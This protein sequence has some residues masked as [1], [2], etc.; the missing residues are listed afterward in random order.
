VISEIVFS[1][2][3]P[4]A[5]PWLDG[6]LAIMVTVGTWQMTMPVIYF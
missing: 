6:I 2:D 3:C 1:S 5:K 4:D